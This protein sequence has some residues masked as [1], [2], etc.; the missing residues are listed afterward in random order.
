MLR[1]FVM[2]HPMILIFVKFNK[3]LLLKAFPAANTYTCKRIS[4][5]GKYEGLCIHI[6]FKDL[7]DLYNIYI[8]VLICVLCHFL[9][10]SVAHRVDCTSMCLFPG[11]SC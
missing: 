9:R 11:L 5:K 7:Y 1:V 4:A 3:L 2:F 10:P 8:T 6:C